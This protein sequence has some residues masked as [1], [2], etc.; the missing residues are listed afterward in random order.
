MDNK[1]P[2]VSY[3]KV[4]TNSD[5][6]AYVQDIGNDLSDSLEHLNQGSPV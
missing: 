2:W 1:D 6:F 3:D 5:A 4:S